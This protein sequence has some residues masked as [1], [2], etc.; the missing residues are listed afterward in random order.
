LPRTCVFDMCKQETN[1]PTNIKTNSASDSDR[2]ALP[3]WIRSY[4]L[5]KNHVLRAHFALMHLDCLRTFDIE[6]RTMTWFRPCF[7]N[8]YPIRINIFF[9]GHI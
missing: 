3:L 1:R 2:P 5:A 7:K 9:C 8:V 6:T 4:A